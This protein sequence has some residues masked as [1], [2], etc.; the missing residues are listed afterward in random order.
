LKTEIRF[1]IITTRFFDIP[2][3]RLNALCGAGSIISL[4]APTTGEKREKEGA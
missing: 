3:P 1:Y 4:L 2:D